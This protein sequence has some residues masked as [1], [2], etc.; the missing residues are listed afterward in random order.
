MVELRNLEIL[1]WTCS[2]HLMKSPRLVGFLLVG[3]VAVLVTG[4]V[5]G[6]GAVLQPVQT[7]KNRPVEFGLLTI[8]LEDHPAAAEPPASFA[9][10]KNMLVV[11]VD[12]FTKKEPV[13]KGV[14][15]VGRT[16]S[17]PQIVFLPVYPAGQNTQMEP[18]STL[19]ALD[20]SGLPSESFL[21]ALSAK[22]I[23]WDHYLLLD[24]TTLAEL[25]KLTGGV[26]RDGTELSGLEIIASLPDTRAAPEAALMAQ[27]KIAS[28]LCLFSA[29]LLQ[30][31]DLEILWGLLTHRMRSDLE[32]ETLEI[33]RDQLGQS[34][35]IPACAFPTLREMTYWTG[36][37]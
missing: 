12:S 7:E 22:N 19:I 20:P 10:Q 24:E 1:F 15:L 6:V 25:A 27:A 5:A 8:R 2:V 26:Y 16:P 17:V 18:W 30:N 3:L 35:E 4:M 34:G 31:I 28:E 37:R 33:V 21:D 23:K 29:D 14:W 13:L 11:L 32:L 36:A 9:E